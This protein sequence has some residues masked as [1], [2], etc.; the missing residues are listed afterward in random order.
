MRPAYK[1]ISSGE[2]NGQTTAG[3]DY[4]GNRGLPAQAIRPPVGVVSQGK[5]EGQSQYVSNFTGTIQAPVS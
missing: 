4:A 1:S 3:N 2:F 5:F